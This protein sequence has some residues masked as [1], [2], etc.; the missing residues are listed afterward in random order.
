M[1]GQ[2][3]RW[4][5]Q[6]SRVGSDEQVERRAVR[7]VHA[8]PPAGALSSLCLPSPSLPASLQPT[9]VMLPLKILQFVKGRL[10]E[11]TFLFELVD[12]LRE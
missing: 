6:Q 5:A 11:E 9:Q 8:W 10:G 12:S 4:G 2:E 3:L 1:T 7:E